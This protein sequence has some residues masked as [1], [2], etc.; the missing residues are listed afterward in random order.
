M[1]EMIKKC[2][3]GSILAL[4]RRLELM[5]QQLTEFLFQQHF[6]KKSANVQHFDRKHQIGTSV[7]F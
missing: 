2:L 4:G 6:S 7:V 3:S 5:S 1:R